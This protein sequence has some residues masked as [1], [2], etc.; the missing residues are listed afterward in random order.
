MQWLC[1]P[2]GG[3]CSEA[4]E[5]STRKFETGE[6]QERESGNSDG[7]G[8]RSTGQCQRGES[9][10]RRETASSCDPEG[11]DGYLLA[12]T[13]ARKARGTDKVGEDAWDGKLL[14]KAS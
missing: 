6:P 2:N 13:F 14:L 8:F 3:N 1:S 10:S 5:L 4:D 12:S 9:K 7:E 11:D